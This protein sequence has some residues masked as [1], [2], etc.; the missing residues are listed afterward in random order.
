MTQPANAIPRAYDAGAV[1]QRIYQTWWDSGYFVPR[2][3]SDR[4]SF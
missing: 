1:E 2:T 3:D 4:E